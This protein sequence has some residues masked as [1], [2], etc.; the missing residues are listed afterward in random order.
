[1]RE[2]VDDMSTRIVAVVFAGLV[3][4]GCAGPR[5]QGA[6]DSK[7]FAT[8]KIAEDRR[9]DGRALIVTSAADD[10]Y[11]FSGPPTS[12]TGR[13]T[14]LSAPL[15]VIA[16]EAAVGVFGNLFRGGAETRRGEAEAFPGT[17]M[18][19]PRVTGFA[20]TYGF[21]GSQHQVQV[22]VHL[23]CRGPDGR[24]IYDK[25]LDSGEVTVWSPTSADQKGGAK[26]VVDGAHAVVQALLVKA[27]G[28]FRDDLAAAISASR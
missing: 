25:D 4:T 9:I 17:V 28:E 20:Y 12:I 22:Q 24:L 18:L 6:F 15:G 21:L 5:Y 19:S 11:V 14:L 16:R 2:G 26:R 27:A 23:A 13:A 1:M 8:L 3:A 7:A 10:G